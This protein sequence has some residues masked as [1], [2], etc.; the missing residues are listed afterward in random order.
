M[1]IFVR[2]EDWI[3]GNDDNLLILSKCLYIMRAFDIIKSKS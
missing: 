1:N 2:M 3:H